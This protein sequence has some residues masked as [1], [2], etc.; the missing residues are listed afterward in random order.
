MGAMRAGTPDS[1]DAMD[2][3]DRDDGGQLNGSSSA[4]VA[5]TTRL[6]A[7]CRVLEAD[8]AGMRER[9]RELET[10]AMEV[11]NFAYVS[12]VQADRLRQ[13]NT[14]LIREIAHLRG[15]CVVC[16]LRVHPVSGS[17]HCVTS[18]RSSRSV[19]DVLPVDDMDDED[20]VSSE[21]SE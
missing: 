18:V 8:A 15:E 16:L 13:H 5:E 21:C 12:R 2:M 4:R 14:E 9:I 1:V 10:D 19:P 11:A 3:E 6:R 7:Y 17:Y 20:D